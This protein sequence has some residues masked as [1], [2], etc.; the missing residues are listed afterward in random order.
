M[1]HGFKASIKRLSTLADRTSAEIFGYI[2]ERL[3]SSK[4]ID[5]ETMAKTM[6]EFSHDFDF[7]AYQMYCDNALIKFGFAK[8]GIHPDYPEDGKTVLYIGEDY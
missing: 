4:P 5:R 3:A 8:R 2:F 6:W 7:S 1:T